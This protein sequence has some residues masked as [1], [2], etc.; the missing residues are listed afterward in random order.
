V[1]KENGWLGEASA[2]IAGAYDLHMRG[3]SFNT[4]KK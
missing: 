1:D 3:I 2:E 4:I